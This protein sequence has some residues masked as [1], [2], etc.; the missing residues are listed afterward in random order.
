[1]FK[2]SVTLGFGTFIAKILGALYRV[3]LTNILGG[4]GLGLYQ[5]VFP[6]Y[7]V[8]L[9]FSG[10][11]V[12]SALSNMISSFTQDEKEDKA[13]IILK[14]SVRLLFILGLSGTLI[15]FASSI[16]LSKLQG[17]SSAYLGYVFLSPSVLLVCL[18]S[19]LRGYFQGLL[20]MKPTAVSQIVEQ[21]LKLALGL[22][23]AKLML[24]NIPKAVAG[25]T[26]AITISELGALIQL[27]FCYKRR[28]RDNLSKDKFDRT[29][30][31]LTAKTIIK[32]TIPIT[33][34]GVLL[35]ISQV[36]DSFLVINIISRYRQDATALFGLLSGVVSTIIN[37]PVSIC[38]GVAVTAIP[39]V[40]SASRL[41][42]KKNLAKKAIYITLLVAVP[43]AL[44][45]YVFSPLAIRIL[46]SGLKAQEKN[47][48]VNLLKLCSPAIVF[49]SLL[50][51]TNAILIGMKKLYLPV[52]TL[53]WGICVKTV[54]NIFLLSN[55]KINIY[56]GGIALIA[57]YFM[58]SLINFI[59]IFSIKVRK[60][61]KAVTNRQ[62]AT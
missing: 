35:P 58:V 47:I 18:I 40:S 30:F 34:V 5:M 41:E 32:N 33:L 43:C 10:A 55:P 28:T 8:L 31:I 16:P 19:C 25:A 48:A 2:N 7:S 14:V 3:P 15:M 46:F 13:R 62:F 53:S 9:D 21:T 42:Q 6:I 60:V 59:L 45:C 54:L 29:E 23:F 49:L 12:P 27:Y 51:T 57:C 20:E 22:F 44:A 11:G 39:T 56:G 1:M 36:V 37:L 52:L 17:N 38:Y 61:D 26:F 50:Q 4:F 24:P